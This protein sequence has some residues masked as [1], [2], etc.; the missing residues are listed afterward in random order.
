MD[1]TVQT[2]AV[3]P[4]NLPEHSFRSGD[5]LAIFK[6]EADDGLIMW[7]TGSRTGHHTGFLWIDEQLYVVESCQS[8]CVGS[9]I[10][11][12]SD[13]GVACPLSSTPRPTWSTHSRAQGVQKT[14][15]KE[16]MPRAIERNFSVAWLPLAD[17]YSQAFNVRRNVSLSSVRRKRG[18]C[19]L[20]STLFNQIINSFN[21]VQ[22]SAAITWFNSGEGLPYGKHNVRV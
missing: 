8:S 11:R 19:A 4:L 6:L 3:E 20:T 16:W 21:A 1:W 22:E 14:L 12:A 7:G 13:K 18:R 17:E 5:Q 15:W 9:Q 2:R 10:V